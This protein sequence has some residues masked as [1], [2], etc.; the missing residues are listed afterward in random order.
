MGE[1]DV[2]MTD[3]THDA[4]LARALVDAEAR[5]RRKM[6]ELL[7]DD[8]LQLLAAARMALST[9]TD[10][11]RVDDLIQRA[12][13]RGRQI[14]RGME[15]TPLV[16]E[17]DVTLPHIVHS[18]QR[19]HGLHTHLQLLAC[20][21]LHETAHDVLLSCAGELL[22]N[23]ARHAPG[24]EARLTLDASARWV[25]IRVDDDGP[26]FGGRTK[27]AEPSAM[28]G[29]GLP[30]LQRRLQALSGDLDWWTRGSSGASVMALLPL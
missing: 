7:H 20:P 16:G 14:C 18:I 2:S 29:M 13:R 12:I 3:D 15:P 8:V 23:V 27:L 30:S 19:S 10:Q 28:G 22:A 11:E 9:S 4:D 17:L 24:C 1:A 21:Q 6:A 25:W 5:E 26:G